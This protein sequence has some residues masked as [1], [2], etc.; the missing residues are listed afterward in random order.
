M[1]EYFDIKVQFVNLTI[2]SST[3]QAVLNFVTEV[4]FMNL[5]SLYST[6]QAVL[7]VFY[8]KVFNGMFKCAE[9]R[10]SIFQ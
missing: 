9:S 5:T 8:L 1:K 2:P 10:I 7:N 4:Q 6:S 3:S